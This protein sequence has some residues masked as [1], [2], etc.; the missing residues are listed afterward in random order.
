V[1]EQN[2]RGTSC[3]AIISRN[4][5]RSISARCR[6]SPSSDFPRHTPRPHRPAGH[7]WHRGGRHHRGGGHGPLTERTSRIR[8]AVICRRASADERAH[9]VDGGRSRFG[10][11]GTGARNSTDGGGV[12][13]RIEEAVSA[14]EPRGHGSAGP[15]SRRDSESPGTVHTP[16]WRSQ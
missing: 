6:T 3:P 2:S 10:D 5:A 16:T 8:Y 12:L 9:S 15:G 11:P 1:S 14:A 13:A 4:V 7:C